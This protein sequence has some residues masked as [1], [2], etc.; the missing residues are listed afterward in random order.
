MMVSVGVQELFKQECIAILLYNSFI[1][2]FSR[3][4]IAIN[5]AQPQL[6]QQFF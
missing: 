5:V 4:F 2:V 3:E 1:A 6:H